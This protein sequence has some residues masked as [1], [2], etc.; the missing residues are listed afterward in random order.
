MKQEAI[1]LLA[2]RT[3]TDSIAYRLVGYLEYAAEA[4]A[5]GK[6]KTTTGAL[7]AAFVQGNSGKIRECPLRPQV[8]PF[9]EKSHARKAGRP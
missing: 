3:L 8:E 4:E 6:S 1:R 9:E 7:L 5:N 2:S